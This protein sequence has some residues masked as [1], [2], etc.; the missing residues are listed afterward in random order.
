ML[1]STLREICAAVGGTLL[2]DCGEPLTAVTTDSR[3]A[4]PGELFIPLVGERFDGHDYIDSALQGGAAACLTARR[5]EALLPGKGYVLVEDTQAA[6]KTLATWHR[7]R[8]HIPFVQITG[9]TGK[10]T[11]KEMVAAVLQRRFRTH[12]THA[13]L[14]NNIGTPLTLLALDADHRAAVIETGM[15]HFGEIRYTGQMVQPDFAVITNVGEVHMENLD[16]T[17]R[18]VLRA[19]CEI[20][21]NLKSDGVAVLNGD[22]DLL[23]EITLDREI[24][25]CGRGE[26]CQVRV[27]DVEELGIEGVRFTVTTPRDVYRVHVTVPGTYMIYPVSM[28]I[29]IGERLGLTKEEI[30]AGISD[31]RPVGS[32]MHLIRL[33]GDRLIIDDCYNAN[34]QSMAAGLQILSG[35]PGRRVAVLG[36]M[37]EL[38]A[39]SRDAHVRM[40]ELAEELGIDVLIAIGVKAKGMTEKRRGETYWFTSVEEAEETL[41][42]QFTPG[43]A[44]LVK[45]SH[46]MGFEKITALLEKQKEE[47]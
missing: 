39:A 47:A 18:G 13:N 45:A 31:Y 16:N 41:L 24:I 42:R 35:T 19:K 11:T 2:Q 46:S 22:D 4:C 29:A 37:G 1:T 5:P 34:P 14:N 26:N 23:R 21:E 27:T 20:F 32:R 25:F 7:E 30:L 36:D 10:T 3:K 9:S 12:K 33:P 40:G 38:G 15:D 43:T 17:R 6:L 44:V 8:F 28:A